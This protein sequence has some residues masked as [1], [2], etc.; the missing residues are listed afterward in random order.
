M[1]VSVCVWCGVCVVSAC[2]CGVNVCGECVYLCVCC[3]CMCLWCGV[4]VVCVCSECVCGECVCL[5]LCCI[6]DFAEGLGPRH[7]YITYHHSRQV[8]I[9]LH[10]RKGF[11]N[12]SRV[13]EMF[14]QPLTALQCF[15][16]PAPVLL[17]WLIHPSS[18][19]CYSYLT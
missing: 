12:P 16:A 13:L 15:S 9:D 6:A 11:L 10:F 19:P 14:A 7:D 2:V 4:S 1:C 5:C 8:K 18:Q 17:P 3:E